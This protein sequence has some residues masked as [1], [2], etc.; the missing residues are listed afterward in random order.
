MQATSPADQVIP[1]PPPP[2]AIV[3]G[4]VTVSG[5]TAT[6]QAVYDALRAQ[7]RELR[8][9]LE[10]LSDRRNDLSSQLRDHPEMDASER[11][12]VTSQIADIDARVAAVNKQIAA[13]DQAT[14]QAAGVPGAVVEEKPPVRTGPPDEVFIIPV[15]FTIFVL[16]PLAIAWARRLW[17]KPV[18]GPMLIPPELAEHMMRLEQTVESMAVEVERIGEGQRFVTKLFAESGSRPLELP[19]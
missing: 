5:V 3:G 15:V 13:S 2:P 17:K 19:K 9:Q 18:A 1:P 11:T 4:K 14:A 7:G 8:N 16:F 12:G 6:P 10:G